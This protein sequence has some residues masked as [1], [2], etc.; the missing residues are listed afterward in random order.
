MYNY[1]HMKHVYI[2]LMHSGTL[3]SRVIKVFYRGK[4]SH[5]AIAL[6]E[7][8]YVTYS[9]GRLK[10]HNWLYGGFVVEKQDGPFFTW[11]K[12]TRCRIMELPVTDEQYAL[13]KERLEE[14]TETREQ[15][16]YDWLGIPFHY[17]RIPRELDKR[18]MC[19]TFVASLLAGSGACEW[20][21]DVSLAKPEDFNNL[22]YSRK[23][24]EG[25]YRQYNIDT[26]HN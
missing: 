20:D 22:P 1:D 15:Y 14:M 9:F 7:D 10:L 25:L 5:I 23:V 3:P 18:Y 16:G 26:Q 21:G 2:L 17:F 4:Y 24:Y 19:S 8:C 13:I 11:F 6:E 12:N